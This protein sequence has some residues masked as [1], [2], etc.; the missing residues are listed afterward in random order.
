MFKMTLWT[1]VVLYIWIWVKYFAQMD[2]IQGQNV[3]FHVEE[4]MH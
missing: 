3:V 4:G 1:N 2:L